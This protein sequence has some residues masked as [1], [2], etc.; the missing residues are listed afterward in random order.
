LA[1]KIT[2]GPV[3]SFT[4]VANVEAARIGAGFA[5]AEQVKA[6]LQAHPGTTIGAAIESLYGVSES[7]LGLW[8]Q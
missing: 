8:P 6:H 5:I 4:Q 1:G 7:E 2:I 3:T